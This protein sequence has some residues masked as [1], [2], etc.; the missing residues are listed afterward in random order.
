MTLVVVGAWFVFVRPQS[1]GGRANYVIVS[2]QSM[3]PG[4]HDGDLVAAFEMGSYRSGDVVAYRVPEGEV[5][6]GRL[7]IHRIIGG[8]AEQGFVV[9]GDNRGF[10]DLWRPKP[11]EI[12]GRMVGYIP[13]AGMAL[14]WLRTPLLPAFVAS[15]IVFSMVNSSGPN[16]NVADAAPKRDRVNRGRHLAPRRGA[17][18]RL[19]G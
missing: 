19:A 11:N 14:V 12:V 4:L 2:G 7:I 15:I 10:P 16:R 18:A 6:Q 1:L 17:P 3:L 9:K 5:G 8:S 13:K